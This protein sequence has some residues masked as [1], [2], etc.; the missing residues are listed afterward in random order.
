MRSNRD[1]CAIQ[2]PPTYGGNFCG[3]TPKPGVEPMISMRFRSQ[4]PLPEVLIPPPVSPTV[5]QMMFWSLSAATQ[6]LCRDYA[7]FVNPISS[8]NGQGQDSLVTLIIAIRT[9]SH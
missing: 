9:R 8:A 6:L 7:R 4:Q 1:G 2:G 3:F 5:G